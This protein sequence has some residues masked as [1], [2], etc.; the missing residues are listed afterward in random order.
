MPAASARSVGALKAFGSTIGTAIA[1]ALAAIA[2]F[3][4]FTISAASEVC[5]PVHW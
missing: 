1:S 5:E 3:I 4:A 2:A